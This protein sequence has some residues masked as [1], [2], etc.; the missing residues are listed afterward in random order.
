[1]M[2]VWDNI[3]QLLFRNN[4]HITFLA[5]GNF[6]YYQI[7][8]NGSVHRA[9]SERQWPEGYIRHSHIYISAGGPLPAMVS[10]AQVNRGSIREQAQSGYRW[11]A[12]PDTRWCTLQTNAILWESHEGHTWAAK[13]FG[14]HTY[15]EKKKRKKDMKPN[16][17][18]YYMYIVYMYII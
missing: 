8:L 9:L 6:V 7:N 2:N 18:I 4:C 15:K 1:M 11:Q 5:E 14:S 16:L 10:G 3:L 12:D 17:V 13:Y